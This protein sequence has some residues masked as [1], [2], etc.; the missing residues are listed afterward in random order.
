LAR[1][2]SARELPA[3]AQ[4]LVATVAEM[5]PRRGSAPAAGQLS[6]FDEAPDDEPEPTVAADPVVPAPVRATKRRPT[7]GGARS[8]PQAA[9]GAVEDLPALLTV[10]RAAAILGLSR[11][12]AYRYAA[13]GDLP[14]QRFGGRVYVVTARIRHLLEGKEE[15]K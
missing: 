2:G 15:P 12:S 5:S 1:Y 6:A 4:R 3:V 13:A 9:R 7:P 11:A 10:P 8:V 14:V